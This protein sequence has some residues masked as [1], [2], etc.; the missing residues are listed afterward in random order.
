[1]YSRNAD[2]WLG[3]LRDWTGRV[4]FKRGLIEARCDVKQLRQLDAAAPPDVIAWL[5]SLVFDYAQQKWIGDLLETPALSHF[6]GLDLTAVRLTRPWLER[7][8]NDPLLV[9]LRRLQVGVNKVGDLASYKALAGGSQLTR[10]RALDATTGMYNAALAAL[11]E[12]PWLAGLTSFACPS[13]F[14]KAV[15]ALVRSPHVPRPA[16]IDWQSVSLN[17]GRINQV[18]DSPLCEQLVDLRLSNA[19]ISAA[20]AAAFSSRQWP[21]LRAL[22]LERT[23]WPRRESERWGRPGSPP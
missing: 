22:S 6:S 2:N 14:G 15:T 12:A 7:L 11:A 5:E 23:H 21:R 16:R 20:E 9:S 4:V 17:K 8:A 3:T 18:V 10:L 19:G 1:L 13:W